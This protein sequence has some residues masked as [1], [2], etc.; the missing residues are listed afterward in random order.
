M[1]VLQSRVLWGILLIL[2]G[3][4]FLLES[5][6][7]LDLGSA[8]A[9]L[10]AAAGLIFGYVFIEDRTKWWTTIPAMALLGIGGLIGLDALLA[11]DVGSWGASLF[12]GSL[13]LA[14]L[15]IYLTTQRE[16]WWALIPGG[17]LVTLAIVVGLEPPSCR[18]RHSWGCS[19][20]GWASP[21]PSSTLFAGRD[22]GLRWALIPAGFG[23]RVSSFCRLLA[24]LAAIVWP[25][26]LIVIGGYVLLRSLRHR[27]EGPR[28]G[29]PSTRQP[30]SSRRRS[31][32]SA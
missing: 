4:L 26:V 15:I 18:T 11:G 10:F 20:W 28:Y 30:G 19:S 12:L 8:W 32:V 9:V 1:K 21:S 25:V 3:L 14:F 29:P 24:G 16:Q 23:A 17:V 5:L 22:K 31:W 7:M 6:E 13:G 2:V 27:A